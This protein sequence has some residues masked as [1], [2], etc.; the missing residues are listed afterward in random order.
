MLF[1][2]HEKVMLYSY[3]S[4]KNKAMILFSIM[5]SNTV[6]SDDVK[7]KPEM[8]LY[9]NKYKAGVDTIDQMLR[10]YTTHQRKNR[11]PLAFFYNNVDIRVCT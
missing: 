2:F 1:G 7:K 4:K 3:I 6:E 8:I 10:R 9:Y 11:W 5:H